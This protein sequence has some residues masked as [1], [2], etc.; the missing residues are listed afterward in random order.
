MELAAQ[1]TLRERE[2]HYRDLYENS[3]D[4]YALVSAETNTVLDCNRTLLAVLGYERHE[5][6]DRAS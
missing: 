6:I 5:L 1:Q 2:V 3:P 4:L